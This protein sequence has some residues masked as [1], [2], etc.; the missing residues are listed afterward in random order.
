MSEFWKQPKY[1]KGQSHLPYSLSEAKPF[2]RSAALCAIE[3]SCP[4][5]AGSTARAQ[6]FLHGAFDRQ[7]D[8]IKDAPQ[9]FVTGLSAALLGCRPGTLENYATPDAVGSVDATKAAE[10]LTAEASLVSALADSLRALSCD[11]NTLEQMQQADAKSAEGG[12]DGGPRMAATLAEHLRNVKQ[13]REALERAVE[14][15]KAAPEEPCP[16]GAP[17][18]SPSIANKPRAPASSVPEY[19]TSTSGLALERSDSQKIAVRV[20]EQVGDTLAKTKTQ[21]ASLQGMV[22]ELPDPE[23]PEHAQEALATV[24]KLQYKCRFFTEALMQDLLKL[25]GVSLRAEEDKPR[26]KTQVW[27]GVLH[28]DEA[29]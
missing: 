23:D 2:L 17:P 28:T 3:H 11:P 15:V 24:G 8:M 4:L 25:D 19:L 26:R 1:S 12:Q 9:D 22:A 21:V 7:G 13:A 20:V 6:R 10:V 16:T 14:E 18:E 27:A 29:W 5:P